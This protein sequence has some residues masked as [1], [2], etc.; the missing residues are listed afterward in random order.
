MELDRSIVAVKNSYYAT[1]NGALCRTTKIIPIKSKSK[2]FQPLD[3]EIR[4]VGPDLAWDRFENPL[5]KEGLYELCCIS[6][7]M[8]GD[9]YIF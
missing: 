8:H 7:P 4:V 6:S 3:A 9:D 2:G 1:K 5:P